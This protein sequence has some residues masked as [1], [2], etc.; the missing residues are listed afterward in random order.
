MVTLKFGAEEEEIVVHKEILLECKYMA[1]KYFSDNYWSIDADDKLL[2]HPHT[3]ALPEVNKMVGNQL[4]NWLYFSTLPYSGSDLGK[5][6]GEEGVKVGS[7][8]VEAYCVA[9]KFEL[10]EWANALA[11]AFSSLALDDMPWIRY[12]IRLKPI[13]HTDEGLRGLVLMCLALDIRHAGWEK[14]TTEINRELVDIIKLGGDFAVGLM[15]CL[16]D[17]EGGAPKRKKRNCNWHVHLT[18]KKCGS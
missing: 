16:L 4:V 5:L 17:T 6:M 10:E 12:A 8:I 15:K 11:D 14:Y 9:M 7:E 3:I 2:I 18:T 13:Q 1:K